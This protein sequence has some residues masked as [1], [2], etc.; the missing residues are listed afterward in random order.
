MRESIWKPE[1]IWNVS[2]GMWMILS[3]IAAHTV[4]FQSLD[5]LVKCIIDSI[6]REFLLSFISEAT[7]EPLIMK[8]LFSVC[9]IAI[10]KKYTCE[11]FGRFSISADLNELYIRFS[12]RILCTFMISLF[13]VC[14]FTKTPPN[15]ALKGGCAEHLS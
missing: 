7:V 14:V 12:R 1:Q 2:A 8:F 3:A 6:A 13:L 10:T 9:W 11:S 15:F 4:Y 5:F